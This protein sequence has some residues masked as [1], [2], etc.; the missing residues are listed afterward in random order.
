MCIIF[1]QSTVSSPYGHTNTQGCIYMRPYCLWENWLLTDCGWP[2][3]IRIMGCRKRNG[4]GENLSCFRSLEE[5][6]LR[7]TVEC[8]RITQGASPGTDSSHAYLWITS[9]H[10]QQ[11]STRQGHSRDTSTI[12]QGLLRGYP[13][14][15][16]MKPK[17][18]WLIG[19]TFQHMS[20]QTPHSCAFGHLMML[21]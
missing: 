12:S 21:P 15:E 1:L 6:S 5:H 17:S 3:K 14:Q 19:L 13:R 16:D 18:H 9:G 10:T 2:L 8:Y 4:F 7:E 20:S 11:T